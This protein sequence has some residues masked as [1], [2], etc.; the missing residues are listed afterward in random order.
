MGC[1]ASRR[2]RSADRRATT[3]TTSSVSLVESLSIDSI[4]QTST[5]DTSSSRLTPPQPRALPTTPTTCSGSTTDR[6]SS[7]TADKK[8]ARQIVHPSRRSTRST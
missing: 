8:T 7:L 2:R 4:A 3:T 1:C 6:T 5:Y